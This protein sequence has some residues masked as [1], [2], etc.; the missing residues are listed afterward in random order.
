VTQSFPIAPASGG[1]LWVLVFLMLVLVAVAAAVGR[2]V[3]A[4][5]TARFEVSP[6]HLTLKG[7]WYG[8]TIPRDSILAD[9]LRVVNL[10]NEPELQPVTRRWGTGL[11][12]YAAGWFRLR[13]GGRALLFLTNQER[14][15]VIPTTLGY[16]VML[17]PQ[18][19]EGLVESLRR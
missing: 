16:V 17:S 15:A 8:R 11:P 12:G 10:R 6:T 1:P 14:V 7:D 5:R 3:I 2:S 4:S 9:E 18:N 19:P 13:N